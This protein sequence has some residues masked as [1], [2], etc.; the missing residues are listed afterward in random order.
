MPT[1]KVVALAVSTDSSTLGAE[2][3]KGVRIASPLVKEQG[4][5]ATATFANGKSTSQTNF[6]WMNFDEYMAACANTNNPET[7]DVAAVSI[8]QD[9]IED[10]EL[11]GFNMKIPAGVS[12][13]VYVVAGGLMAGATPNTGYCSSFEDDTVYHQLDPRYIP[14]VSTT[15]TE[16]SESANEVN[17]GWAEV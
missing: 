12:A 11:S 16:A 2:M 3:L 7:M 4:A 9:I 10:H 13:G 17:F 1:E 8:M 14:S 15:A 6:F 5:D